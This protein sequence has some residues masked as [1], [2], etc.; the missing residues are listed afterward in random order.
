MLDS[1]HLKNSLTLLF[2]AQKRRIKIATKKPVASQKAKHPLKMRKKSFIEYDGI[3]IRKLED[4]KQ[5]ID[6]SINHLKLQYSS[7][8]SNE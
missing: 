5:A 7:F 2:L 3:K 6:F 8:S 4:I 1:L